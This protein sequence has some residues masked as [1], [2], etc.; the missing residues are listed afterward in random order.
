MTS[1]NFGFIIVVL[2]WICSCKSTMENG[3]LELGKYKSKSFNKIELTIKRGFKNEITSTGLELYL[4]EDSSF[5]FKTCGNIITGYFKF[6]TDTLILLC[7]K[8][9]FLVDTSKT[10]IYSPPSELKFHI[11][12]KKTLYRHEVGTI[13][14][15]R[16]NFSD[17]LIKIS[18]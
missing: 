1:I 2:F 18:E 12:N 4:K 13:N 6:K 11:V 16:V 3:R 17:N 14:N 7:L 10:T 8:N 15:K 5:V 9:T